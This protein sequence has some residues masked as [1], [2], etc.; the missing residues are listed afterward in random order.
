M[1]T[2][3]MLKRF[4]RAYPNWHISDKAAIEVMDKYKK[5]KKALDRYFES[6]V[7]KQHDDPR[8]KAIELLRQGADLLMKSKETVHLPDRDIVIQDGE[9]TKC[10]LNPDSERGQDVKKSELADLIRYLADMMGN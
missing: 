2:R 1:K 7:P 4:R 6:G 8:E 10:L 5:D 9:I 3:E